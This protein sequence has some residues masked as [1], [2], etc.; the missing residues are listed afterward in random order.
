MNVES[1][2]DSDSDSDT[3]LGL[4]PSLLGDRDSSQAKNIPQAQGSELAQTGSETFRPPPLDG[5]TIPVSGQETAYPAKLACKPSKF[6]LIS[7]SEN[8]TCLLK[9]YFIVKQQRELSYIIM[10]SP[11]MKFSYLSLSPLQIHICRNKRIIKSFLLLT[12]FIMLMLIS[13]VFI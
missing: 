11:V 1:P 13:I 2:S 6:Y 10:L 12:G 9:F 5:I 3:L 7:C 4:P 8:Y